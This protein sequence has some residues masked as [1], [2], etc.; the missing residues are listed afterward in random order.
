MLR[1]LSACSLLLAPGTKCISLTLVVLFAYAKEKMEGL[2]KLLLLEQPADP[3]AFLIDHLKNNSTYKPKVETT[4]EIQR[5]NMCVWGGSS[6]FPSSGITM[7]PA[8]FS[9]HQPPRI[10]ATKA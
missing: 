8:P 6:N 4:A 7:S 3:I 10:L 9:R 1:T 5:A 2:L